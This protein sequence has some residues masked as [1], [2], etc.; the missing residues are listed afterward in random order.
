MRIIAKLNHFSKKDLAYTTIRNA[1]VTGE[2]KPDERLL[3]S[4]LAGKLGVSEIPIREAINRL[5]SESFIRSQGNLHHVAPLTE[6]E[7]LDMLEV[8]LG[9]EI[10]AIRTAVTKIDKAGIEFQ[11]AL[12]LKMEESLNKNDLDEYSRLH[13]EFHMDTFKYCGIAYLNRA[14]IDAW[15][16][17]ERGLAVFNLHPWDTKPS[18]EEHKMIIDLMEKSDTRNLEA[19]FINHRRKAFNMY[20]EKLRKRQV[21]GDLKKPEQLVF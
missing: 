16:H 4:E 6:Q 8:R 14:L 5:N 19:F 17:H 11:R 13:K 18:L 12:L 2:L 20:F 21:V 7:F 10:I 9:L 1:I 3:I 15:D